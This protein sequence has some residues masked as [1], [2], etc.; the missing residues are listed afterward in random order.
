M[1][2]AGPR[3]AEDVAPP[4][5]ERGEQNGEAGDQHPRRTAVHE[6]D[7]A[8]RERQRGNGAERRPRARI[9]HVIG[10]GLGYCWARHSSLPPLRLVSRS[11]SRPRPSPSTRRPSPATGRRPTRKKVYDKVMVVASR[12]VASSA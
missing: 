8:G 3:L 10:V 12:A 6:P 4:E 11:V 1:I 5:E 2:N 7:T 9:D